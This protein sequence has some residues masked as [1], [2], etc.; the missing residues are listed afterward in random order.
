MLYKSGVRFKLQTFAG[1]MVNTVYRDEESGIQDRE[2]KEESILALLG[3]V[4]TILNLAVI[5][6]VYLYTTL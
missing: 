3:I 4:G 5:I 1:K 6:F 2:G